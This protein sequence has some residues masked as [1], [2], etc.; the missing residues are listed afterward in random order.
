M[1]FLP[2]PVLKPR[3]HSHDLVRKIAGDNITKH[4]SLL[5]VYYYPFFWGEGGFQKY[6][7]Y[8]FKA[9]KVQTSTMC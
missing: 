7:M 2:L 5:A 8:M 4:T 9:L 3:H 6:V 1:V